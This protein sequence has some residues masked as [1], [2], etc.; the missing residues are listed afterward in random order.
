MQPLAFAVHLGDVIAM[1]QGQATGSDS[2]QYR[3]DAGYEQ[4][5]RITE[6][7]LA[8]IMIELNDEFRKLKTSMENV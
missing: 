5:F 8:I 2:L 1:M 3:L 4:H 6:D 7:D